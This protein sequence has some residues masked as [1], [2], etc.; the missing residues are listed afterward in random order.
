MIE[1]LS[2]KKKDDGW[3]IIDPNNKDVPEYGP[4]D[5]KAEAEDCKR[6]TERFWKAYK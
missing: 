4:Y 3:W 5:T 1:P 6:G 2:L